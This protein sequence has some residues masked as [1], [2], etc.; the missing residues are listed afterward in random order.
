MA[1]SSK[2]SHCSS[3][4]R[5][6]TFSTSE[7][8]CWKVFLI[9]TARIGDLCLRPQ[10]SRKF[11]EIKRFTLACKDQKEMALLVEIFNFYPSLKRHLPINT[12]G[13]L[14][15]I[16][17]EF[18]KLLLGIFYGLLEL[19]WGTQSRQ[20]SLA[21]SR[22]FL[23]SNVLTTRFKRQRDNLGGLPRPKLPIYCLSRIAVTVYHR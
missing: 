14:G 18:A 6:R 16:P 13:M 5:Q 21:F 12:N 10:H 19:E 4:S 15:W 17:H 20:S 8:L 2:G 3:G 1:K 7:S 11:A 22:P 9:S 23:L